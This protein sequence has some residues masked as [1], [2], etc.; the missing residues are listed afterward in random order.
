MYKCLCGHMFSF[1][2]GNITGSGIP[3]SMG[4]SV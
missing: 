2:L 3:L 4:N 1:P